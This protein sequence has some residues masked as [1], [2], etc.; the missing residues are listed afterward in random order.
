VGR[1]Q[2]FQQLGE[3]EVGFGRGLTSGEQIA[4]GADGVQV[5][6]EPLLQ[7][8]QPRML[9]LEK[10][11]LFLQRRVV[12]LAGAGAQI[13]DLLIQPAAERGHPP[14]RYGQGVLQ[15][16]LSG[17]EKQTDNTTPQ[18]TSNDPPRMNANRVKDLIRVYSR[19]FA[20]PFPCIR[21]SIKIAGGP[22]ADASTK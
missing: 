14:E 6:G 7:L 1:V 3:A 11:K 8:L 12:K 10:L 18:H 13:V 20:A 22:A 17:L 5:G 2:G 19:P 9:G 21:G 4:A 16:V 15:R